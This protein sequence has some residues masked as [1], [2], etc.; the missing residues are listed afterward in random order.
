MKAQLILENGMVFEGRAFGYLKESIG[1]VVFNTSMTG[2]QEILTNPAYYGQMLVMTYPLVGN[3]GINL[4][5]KES[6]KTYVQALITREKSDFPN[7]FRCE[8]TLD[9]YLKANH[10]L[11]IDGI[12]TRALTKVIRDYGTMKGIIAIRELTPSQIKLKLDAFSNNNA[13]SKVTSSKIKAIAGTGRHIGILDLGVRQSVINSLKSKGCKITVF[14]AFTNIDEILE[15]NLDGVLISSG[16]GSP[17]D[18]PD[19]IVNIEK[20]IGKIPLIGI[21]LGHQVLGLALGGDICK[22]K[23]GH[24][25]SNQPVQNMLNNKIQTT[26]QCHN[27]VVCKLPKEAVVSHININDQ[28]IEGMYIKEKMIYSIQFHPQAPTVE[29]E[30]DPIFDD[31][32]TVIQGG[33]L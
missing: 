31:F 28:T 33:T 22:L 3:Y 32:L 17:Q 2:Y 8:L 15:A 26:Q 25:G 16:P 12:D 10:I 14:P 13:V 1:E 29:N 23:F 19:I 20:L 21:G 18:I 24:N 27:Y 5:D 7:N 6:S 9:G 4:D 30:I 11:G